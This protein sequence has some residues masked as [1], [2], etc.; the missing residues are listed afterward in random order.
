[1]TRHF[2][3][4]SERET[5]ELLRQNMPAPTTAASSA[6]ARALRAAYLARAPHIHWAAVQSPVGRLHLAASERGLLRIAFESDRQTF[7]AELD[8]RAH[9]K[10]NGAYI[11]TALEQLQD[12]F[13]R[14]AEPFELKLDLAE[15]T[16]FQRR[17]LASIRAIPTGEVWSYADVAAAIGKPR[18]ARAVGQALGSNPIPIV[19][20]CHRVVA[21]DGG[22][23]GYS[24]GLDRK[25]YLLQHE[26]GR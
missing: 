25:R 26:G 20:P 21:S 7:L 18:A 10:H 11:E 14:P 8:P 5:A 24:G 15:L 13:K 16:S 2:D 1:M 6:S 23:G 17:V 12:Y 3:P 19:I 4:K 9:L 22:L